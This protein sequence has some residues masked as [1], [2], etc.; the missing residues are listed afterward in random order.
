MTGTAGAERWE[1]DVAELWQRAD[2]SRP[3]EVL[4]G[5]RVLWR[6]R[7][8]QDADALAEWAGAHD[9]VGRESDAIP[10]YRRSLERGVAGRR[11]DEVVVQLASSLRA[12]GDPDAA[13]V[14]LDDHEVTEAMRPAAQ[15]F[16]ALALRDLGRAEEAL[17]VALTALAPTLGQYR[18]A[19]ARYAAR[20]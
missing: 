6:R 16:R 7:G 12:V 15:A 5:M 20:R 9:F 2:R 18:G 4:D 3:A 14:V 19:V 1:A 13:I 17:T 10:L 11:R 8:E